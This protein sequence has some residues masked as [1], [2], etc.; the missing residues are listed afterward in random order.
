MAFEIIRT[1]AGATV[2][3]CHGIDPVR[4]ILV[5]LG[6]AFQC[7]IG[8]MAVSAII[9]KLKIRPRHRHSGS[10][11]SSVGVTVSGTEG[12]RSNP[13]RGQVIDIG[14]VAEISVMTTVAGTAA[15]IRSS[16]SS[17]HCS[18]QGAGSR[19]DQ[20]RVRIMAT[21]ASVMDLGISRIDRITHCRMASRTINIVLDHICMVRSRMTDRTIAGNCGS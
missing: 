17:W 8:V 4:V 9:M 3:R 16:A 2:P 7:P 20:R 11:A 5:R 10:S 13:N 18:Y 19:I 15:I 12:V 1:V 14:M 21:D 6:K